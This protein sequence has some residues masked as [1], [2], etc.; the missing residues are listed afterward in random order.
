MVILGEC[1]GV[2][3]R[4]FCTTSL[5]FSLASEP[6]IFCRMKLVELSLLG[7]FCALLASSSVM[8]EISVSF[9]GTWRVLQLEVCFILRPFLLA[10][11]QIETVGRRR[12]PRQLRR[13]PLYLVL[14]GTVDSFLHVQERFRQARLQGGL[15]QEAQRSQRGVFS[16]RKW[17]ESSLG[18][19]GSP[20]SS[21]ASSA[22]SS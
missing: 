3:S 20:R 14:L 17:T 13:D 4:M 19:P 7:D 11:Q 2:P 1:F 6:K 16:S 10:R 21:S 8:T 18:S 22:S 15:G 12:P 5:F 9:T